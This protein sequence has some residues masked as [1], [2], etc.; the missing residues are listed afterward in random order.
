MVGR[1]CLSSCAIAVVVRSSSRT[2]P[3]KALGQVRVTFDDDDRDNV[4]C[5]AERCRYY[6][7]R[8]TETGPKSK[9]NWRRSVLRF[10]GKHSTELSY[11]SKYRG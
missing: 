7:E 9:K 2:P 4:G 3:S 11:T 5:R 10:L 8:K 1:C 6:D